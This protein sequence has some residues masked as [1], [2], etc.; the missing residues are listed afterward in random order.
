MLPF[1]IAPCIAGLLLV[2]HAALAWVAVAFFFTLFSLAHVGTTRAARA[3]KRHSRGA[4]HPVR[5]V[6][7]RHIA[8][9]DAS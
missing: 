4:R 3:L 9:F 6:A 8:E 1:V 2:D 7:V 5:T